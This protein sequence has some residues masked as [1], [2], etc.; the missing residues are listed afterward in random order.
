[1]KSSL[2][3]Q[4][5]YLRLY[6]V[7]HHSPYYAQCRAVSTTSAIN[8]GL[9]ASRDDRGGGRDRSRSYQEFPARD[10][11]RHTRTGVVRQKE[12]TYDDRPTPRQQGRANYVQGRERAAGFSGPRAPQSSSRK[13]EA[14]DE[15]WSDIRRVGDLVQAIQQAEES[16]P[17]TRPDVMI[18]EARSSLDKV[19]VELQL[20]GAG[21]QRRERVFYLQ[22]RLKGLDAYM[23][24]KY[25]G[26]TQREKTVVMEKRDGNTFELALRGKKAGAGRA[27]REQRAAPEEDGKETTFKRLSQDKGEERGFTAEDESKVED[28]I[29]RMRTLVDG[30]CATL[31]ADPDASPPS[32]EAKEVHSLLH[33]TGA[34]GSLSQS[35]WR[36]TRG[37]QFK[38]ILN[39]QEPGYSLRR[40]GQAE[41][42]DTVVSFL[43][44]VG[45]R[46]FQLDFTPRGLLKGGLRGDDGPANVEE[47]LDAAQVE[48]VRAD[49]RRV[50][51]LLQTI[52]AIESPS[53]ENTSSVEVSARGPLIG[54]V[55]ALVQ[56]LNDLARTPTKWGVF[57]YKR[58]HSALGGL[59]DIYAK[60]N[61]AIDGSRTMVRLLDD[62]MHEVV[63]KGEPAI[64]G[65]RAGSVVREAGAIKEAINQR[66]AEPASV[67]RPR[68]G[69]A[70]ASF[71]RTSSDDMAKRLVTQRKR[72][73]DDY[74]VPLSVPYTTSASEFLYG[75]NVVLAA[76]RA[77][78]RKLY[79][80]YLSPRAYNRETGNAQQ[81]IDL[82]RRAGIAVDADANV[83][84]LDKMSDNRPHNGVLL[85]ASKL[86][87]PPVLSLAKPDPRTSTIP[88]ALDRQ[89]AEDVAVNGAPA[90]I[91][92]STK[93]WR[94]PF[95]VMLDGIVDPGNLGNI[96]RTA[97][98]FGVDAVAVATNTCAPLSSAVL[99]KA[100]SGACEAVRLLAL[101][102]PSNFV[103]ESAKAGWKIFAAVAP[104]LPGTYATA[105]E[106]GK[107]V[108]TTE[109]AASSPLAKQPCILMLGA[110]GE[111]LRA[112]LTSKADHLLSIEGGEK[113]RETLDVGVDSLN[114]G[115]AAGVLMEAFLR[116]PPAGN[117][118]V[119][120]AVQE[121]AGGDLGF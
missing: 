27:A 42:G 15:I 103:F 44:K 17:H 120:P 118:A 40:R 113:G 116:K 4:G 94:Q 6:E 12:T 54:E 79:R 65:R 2:S 89:T 74:D 45:D 38:E 14:P 60:R 99:A 77:Q 18:S 52:Q 55:R 67:L 31:A 83:R 48:Q 106:I 58:F 64:P 1:M 63:E 102:K 78:R 28:N 96:L 66:R 91:P 51:T 34:F 81:I 92:S 84:L 115:V 56:K 59:P 87:A 119:T 32:A 90:A 37:K 86:P 50:R 121:S 29:R 82:A 80:L 46:K 24:E 111:G 39:A 3:R 33:A 72:S 8:K 112:N 71:D 19:N 109:L 75:F 70:V 104:T 25:S 76:L 36:D 85:E 73:D 16:N 105:K 30:I 107:Q 7:L 53:A 43:G 9:R 98:F 11:N 26:E 93:T 62:T 23:Q 95:V 57:I 47:T 35:S 13:E 61:D 68:E 49:V 88:L 10:K 20:L 41:K 114:V 21:E 110:E 100:S 117:T 97:H 22:R 101:P 69:A 5:F 108:S